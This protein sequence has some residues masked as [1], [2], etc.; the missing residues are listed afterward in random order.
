M[1]TDKLVSILKSL[2]LYSIATRPNDGMEQEYYIKKIDE[3]FNELNFTN[4]D[5]YHTRIIKA[6]K[7]ND[8]MLYFEMYAEVSWFLLEGYST[9]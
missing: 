1:D 8:R 4:M 3:I 6:I 2:N 7:E 5:Y 9:F